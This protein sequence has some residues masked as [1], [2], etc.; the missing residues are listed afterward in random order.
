MDRNITIC[1][2]DLTVITGH[3]PYKSKDEL[4][5]KFWK[6]YFKSDY[7]E[8]IENLKKQNIKLKKEETD[9]EVVK[10]IVK[11]NNINLG[12]DLYKCFKSNNVNDLNKDKAKVMK[13]IESSLPES[14]KNEFKKSFNTITNTNFGIKYE[15]KGC[16]LYESKTNSTVVK[17]SKYYKTELF[18]IPNEYD[19]IDTWGIGGKIDGILLPENKIVEIKNRVKNLFYSLRDYE[20][21]QCFVYMFL[22]ESETTDL[23]EVLKQ[24][25]DNSINIINV[26]FNEHFWEA[27][28]M[29]RLEEFI[30]DFYIFLEDPKKKMELIAE[31][32]EL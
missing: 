30:S 10:R 29:M 26:K 19:K 27:E 7:L 9:Y 24:K 20:K 2:T 6:R 4:V 18:Q 15:N 14:K 21:V 5:L 32:D 13:K 31:C 23:V 16:D 17:T 3:N 12:G 1:A 28:I 25:D 11:E 22:L 8:C